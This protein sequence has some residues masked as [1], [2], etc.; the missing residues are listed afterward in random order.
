M[1]RV[2]PT[3][4]DEAFKREAVRLV[5]VDGRTITDV[6]RDSGI[7]RTTIYHWLEEVETHCE[8]AFTGSGN[9]HDDERELRRLETLNREL[10]EEVEIPKEAMAIFSR[11]AR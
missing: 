7:D 1:V 6:S 9:I 10:Q 8:N 3:Y 11:T 2:K 5:Q 4:Y